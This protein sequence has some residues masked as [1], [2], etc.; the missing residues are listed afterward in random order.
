M[1]G[2]ALSPD[3]QT[4]EH[5]LDLDGEP[6]GVV[7]LKASVKR[8]VMERWDKGFTVAPATIGRDAHVRAKK[9]R[10]AAR[11]KAEAGEAAKKKAADKRATKG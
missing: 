5:R 9:E 4:G 1:S 7:K 11:K 10:I 6:V 8:D 2:F 3:P